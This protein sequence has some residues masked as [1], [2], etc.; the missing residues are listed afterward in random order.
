M[1]GGSVLPCVP[2]RSSSV[3]PF[4]VVV[5]RSGRDETTHFG[6]DFAFSRAS[7]RYCSALDF[8]RTQLPHPAPFLKKDSIFNFRF[9][10]V[11][12]LAKN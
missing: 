7:I 6:F 8:Y 11:I 5:V 3:F 4:S 12:F 2:F 9:S 1:C 10:F